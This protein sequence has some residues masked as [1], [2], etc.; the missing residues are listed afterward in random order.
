MKRLRIVVLSSLFPN[1][2]RKQSG[3]FV[4]ERMFRVAEFA[5]IEVIS[6][7]PWFPGQGLIRLFKPN[8]RPMPAKKEVQ[9]GITVHFPRFLSIPKFFRKLDGTMMAR[10]A[11]K[12]AKQ[13]ELQQT[14]DIIDSHFTYPDG[15]AATKVAQRLNKKVTITL[16][17]TE[18]THSQ[19]PEKLKLML[20]AWQDADHMFCVAN[21]LKQLAVSLGAQEDK[22]TVVGNGV[23]THKFSALEPKNARR[24]MGIDEDAKVL[25]TVGGLVR[26]KGFH[27]VIDCLPELLL[28]YPNLVYLIVGGASA[29]GNIEA[30]LRAQVNSLD[31]EEHVKFLGSL[32][33]NKLSAPLSSADL[34]VLSTANEGWANVIL[35][36]MAC[37]TPVIASDVG[38]NSEVIN[39]DDVGEIVPFDDHPALF[40]SI[41]Q[42]LNKE[43]DRQAIVNYAQQNHWDTR[44]AK[45]MEIYNN[46]VSLREH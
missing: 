36:S 35:E 7:V 39:S 21:S 1:S 10:A 16:R 30:E 3:L 20:Q 34:F 19:D 40:T 46:L 13:L 38:G 45:I 8:Y 4:R 9:Q 27:R 33:P 28:S 22:F 32:P 29:E 12:V 2:V 31:L 44:M 14:I 25:I 6:P 43:W 18:L 17:G 24:Q 42:G 11:Y 26:R 5:D 37:G 23:D 41:K 15:L